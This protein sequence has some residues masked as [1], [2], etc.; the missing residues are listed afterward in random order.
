MK[1]YS[2]LLSM[3][4]AISSTQIVAQDDFQRDTI[5]MN[6]GYQN[7]VYYSLDQQV[8]TN[9]DNSS[10]DLAFRTTPMTVGVYAN[11]GTKNWN[12]TQLFVENTMATM[13]AEDKFMTD[14]TSEFNAL[15]QSSDLE[16]YQTYNSISTWDT[17]ALNMWTDDDPQINFNM[18]WGMYDMS[19]HKILG[20]KVFVLNIAPSFPGA[21]VDPSAPLYKVYIKEH[22]PMSAGRSWEFWYAPL[23]A[24]TE[25]EI[26]KIQFDAEEY[27][28][29]LLVYFNFESEELFSEEPPVNSW[30][31]V[32][33]RYKELVA[34]G[35]QTMWYG[36][37]GVLLNNNTAATGALN[38]LPDGQEFDPENDSVYEFIEWESDMDLITD[39]INIIGRGWRG[40]NTNSEYAI[41]PNAYF[42]KSKGNKIYHVRFRRA[43]LG[44]S[45]P[46]G[47][48]AG[49]IVFEYKMV[50]DVTS[51]QDWKNDFIL[52][53]YPNPAEREISLSI[54]NNGASQNGM[55]IITDMT[56]RHL[57]QRNEQIASGTSTFSL[58][59][60][61]FASG[62][63]M[64][65]IQLDQGLISKKIIKK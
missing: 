4:L 52:S 8:K 37:T 50:E 27:G 45:A 1:K 10:W 7:S 26:I 49:D 51:I 40:N 3:G 2:L 62:M 18:G 46:E 35:P 56:G 32:F 25:A 61:A 36:V 24:T 48:E 58:D 44:S 47:L 21:P 63:Y 5:S 34:A 28:D 11:Q 12:V 29:Q 55:I 23:D 38:P 14:L 22:N 9:L 20:H 31:F 60:S 39:D 30:D 41:V 33:T 57:L 16:S 42:V 17:G 64:V 15:N 65:Y 59:M 19:S 54:D 53:I 43:A 13:T 6:Q